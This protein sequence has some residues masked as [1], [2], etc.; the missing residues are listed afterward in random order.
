MRFGFG[1]VE[2]VFVDAFGLQVCDRLGARL[3]QV[4][5]DDG[6]CVRAGKG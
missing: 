6:H 4:L 2:E 5:E 1:R 3:S